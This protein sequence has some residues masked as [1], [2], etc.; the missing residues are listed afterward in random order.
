MDLQAVFDITS[1]ERLTSF[2][3]N[4]DISGLKRYELLLEDQ[5]IP[6]SF[7][8]GTFWDLHFIFASRRLRLG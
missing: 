1:F 3:V 5:R 8:R 2:R 7:R 6:G 4:L